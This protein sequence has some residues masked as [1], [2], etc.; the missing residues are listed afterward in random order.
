[1]D[2]G[3]TVGLER[4]SFSAVLPRSRSGDKMLR[5]EAPQVY[6]DRHNNLMTA[7]RTNVYRRRWHHRY[8]PDELRRRIKTLVLAWK[9]TPRLSDLRS[10]TH[11]A[12]YF[13]Y[14]SRPS[15]TAHQFMDHPENI[16]VVQRMV[17]SVLIHVAVV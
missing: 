3:E 7:Q 8:G 2:E 17:K 1:M 15:F 14:L 9:E 12:G 16:R 13:G 5:A 4:S 10:C 11:L 6:T